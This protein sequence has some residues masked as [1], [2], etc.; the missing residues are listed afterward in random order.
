MGPFDR[1]HVFLYMSSAVTTGW[2][3][4]FGTI[5]LYALTLPNTNRFLGDRLYNGSPYGLLYSVI[6]YDLEGL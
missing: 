2:P 6:S 1:L 5:I 4:K 3:K